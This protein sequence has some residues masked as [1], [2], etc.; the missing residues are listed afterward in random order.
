LS[1]IVGL[2]Q[3][4]V[5]ARETMLIHPINPIINSPQ[6]D[7]EIMSA[8]ATE[9]TESNVVLKSCD[10][11]EFHTDSSLLGMIS[12]VLCGMFKMPRLATESN[13]TLIELSE[14]GDQIAYIL[15][16]VYPFRAPQEDENIEFLWEMV[17][18]AGKYAMDNFKEYLKERLSNAL[19]RGLECSP[20]FE[21]RVMEAFVKACRLGW[22]KEIRQWSTL[23]LTF[24]IEGDYLDAILNQAGDKVALAM[25]RLHNFRRTTVVKGL[26]RARYADIM[27][28]DLANV[29]GH[30][31][32]A[33]E[34][35]GSIEFNPELPPCDRGE[36]HSNHLCAEKWGAFI[37]ALANHSIPLNPD[38]SSTAWNMVWDAQVDCKKQGMGLTVREVI[39]RACDALPQ[40]IVIVG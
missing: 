37:I 17:G 3:S 38:V 31:P 39:R 29:S 26:M 30:I 8:P 13:S 4:I 18:V 11:M 7:S 19:V 35:L 27:S 23:T 14:R 5:A 36:D 16:A 24:N 2:S 12:P 15:R 22:S 6:I 1:T 40:Q 32:F 9:I 25:K 34:L 20:E 21:P 28:Y 33:E 10:G